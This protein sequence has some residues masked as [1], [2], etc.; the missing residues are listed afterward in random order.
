MA[1]GAALEMPCT[2]NC[3]VGSN[4]TPSAIFLELKCPAVQRR[5]GQPVGE[6]G[7]VARRRPKTAGEA[8]SL[9]VEPAV[10]GANEANGSLSATGERLAVL[11]GE[12]A[13]PC[14]PQS[15]TAGLN[16]LSRAVR[17]E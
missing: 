3:T 9:Y 4:P 7:P 14:N 17:V 12:V 8:Y 2:G 1:E 16:S 10:E 11:D 6:K 15:A 13:V 5:K